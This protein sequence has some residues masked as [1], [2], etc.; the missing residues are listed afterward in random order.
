MTYQRVN[1]SIKALTKE[2][3]YVKVKVNKI[4][5]T[6]NGNGKD[7]IKVEVDRLKQFKKLIIWICGSLFII[8]ITYLISLH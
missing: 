4:D 1:Q 2:I 8:I 6:L 3:G 5:E 7:G